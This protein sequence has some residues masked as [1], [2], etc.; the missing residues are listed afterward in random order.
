MSGGVGLGG[1]R[2]SFVG[3]V[4]KQTRPLGVPDGEGI[5][6]LAQRSVAEVPGQPLALRD[7]AAL[8]AVQTGSGG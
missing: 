6:G 4:L 7:P 5:G 2:L 3:L 1:G 8:E